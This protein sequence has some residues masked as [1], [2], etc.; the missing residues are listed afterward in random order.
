MQ[1]INRDQY[2]VS[3]PIML[4]TNMK[5]EFL[6]EVYHSVHTKHEESTD[7][8]ASLSWECEK[9]K[10]EVIPQ[11]YLFK[12]DKAAP[13]KMSGFSE[14]DVE[15]DILQDG[16]T[17]FKDSDLFILQDIPQKYQGL[18]QLKTIHDYAEDSFNFE[19]SADAII[20]VGLKEEDAGAISGFDNAEF[21]ITVLRI[22]K[23]AKKDEE[24]KIKAHEA[25]VFNVYKK[26]FKK[27]PVEIP[28]NKEDK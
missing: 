12:S 10:E 23:D 1:G 16:D 14:K 26:N 27:G 15:L 5:Y 28:L 18:T 17:A 7:S 11:A 21:Q 19:A 22:A 9:I 2:A 3:K 4:M 25:I 20:Y 13:L 8:Y 24:C 6:F